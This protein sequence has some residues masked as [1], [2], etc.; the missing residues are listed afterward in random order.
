ML[1][2]SVSLGLSV[3]LLLVA[4]GMVEGG[5]HTLQG[6][7]G[8]ALGIEQDTSKST[9]Y[10]M[11]SFELELLAKITGQD[12][13]A[14]LLASNMKNI[15]LTVADYVEN[16]PFIGKSIAN[17]IRSAVK[18]SG[19]DT[20]K[21]IQY[22]TQE[23]LENANP[24][25]KKAFKEEGQ[26][27]RRSYQ[28]GFSSLTDETRDIIINEQ[29]IAIDKSS[30]IV[31]RKAYNA[32]Q[33]EGQ[34]VNEGIGSESL[35]TG[36]DK[37]LNTGRNK[38]DNSTFF[39]EAKYLGGTIE[40]GYS[41]SNLNNSTLMLISS[42]KNAL[43]NSSL[44][45]EGQRLPETVKEGI[46]NRSWTVEDE[47]R[48]VAY[49]AND[50][51]NNA[52]NGATSGANLVAGIVKGIKDNKYKVTNAITGAAQGAISAF[53]LAL[54]IHSPSK[55]MAEQA[56][57]IPLGI[58]EGVDSTSDKA[59]GSMKD[60]V[61]GMQDTVDGIDYS[62]VAQIPKISR[63]AVKYVP[64]QAISTNEIQRSIVGQDNNMLNRVLS[65]MQSSSKGKTTLIVPFSIDGEE[66]FRKTIELNEAY[67][68]AT[69][70]GGL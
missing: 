46:K 38:L 12:S 37:L 14:G 65:M 50:S 60:M 48:N 44:Y 31:N 51:L 24:W 42:A 32:G 9:I 3:G 41:T 1:A 49:K 39:Q 53:N 63:N 45:T 10:Y 25:V 69:N 17:G 70:G 33:E 68:L 62:S 55:V 54:G 64:K 4:V 47:A 57:F 6:Q 30:P 40:Q 34:S 19:A 61:S 15:L 16:I 66:W 29:A 59:I 11:I 26:E 5:K 13:L 2:G 36:T 8:K 28:E 52:I 18:E 21:V 67:N 58:A 27:G 35:E 43:N 20:T 7:I 22:S 56:K 23:A